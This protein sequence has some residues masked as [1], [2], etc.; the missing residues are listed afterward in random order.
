MNF[1]SVDPDSNICSAQGR[2]VTCAI[3]ALVSGETFVSTIVIGTKGGNSLTAEATVTANE[4]D[5][6]IGNNSD[7][8][9]VSVC[10]RD[11]PQ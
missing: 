6:D 10:R 1:E 3:G 5:P 11:C 7:D 2:N 8:V 9:T 4:A